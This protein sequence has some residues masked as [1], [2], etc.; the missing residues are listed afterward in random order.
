MRK[1]GA[2]FRSTTRLAGS[3]PLLLLAPGLALAQAASPHTGSPEALTRLVDDYCVSCH[4]AE[5]WAGSLAIDTLDLKQVDQEPK[6]WETTINKLR[7]RLM[8]PAGQKQPSQADVD[9]VVGFLETSLDTSAKNKV[10][11]VPIQRLNRNEFAAT[12]KELIGV[13][14]DARQA[15]PTE[16]EVEGFSNIAENLGVSPAFMEQYLSATRRAVRLAIGEPVPKMAKVFI[17]ANV[18][19]PTAYPLGTRANANAGGR[20]AGMTFTHVFPADG[21]YRVNVTEEDN[22][23]I[24]LYPRGAENPATMVI[25]VDGVE[26]GRKEI[27]GGEWLDIADRDG[28]DG[29]DVI[30]KMIS[31]PIQVKAGRREV[32]VTFIDRARALSNDSAGGGGFGGGGRINNMPIIQTGIEIEGPFQPKGLSMNESRA[33]IFVCQPKKP[34]DERPC[35]EQIARNMATKAFRRPVND[36]DVQYLMKFYEDGRQEE[37]GFDAGVTE[38]VTAILS[39]PD[40]LYRAIPA[41]ATPGE[42]R[43]LTDLE[44][45]SRLSFFLWNTVPDAQLLDL[46]TKGRLSDEA[47]MNAQVD[48]MLKD[49]RARALIENFALAWLNLDELDQVDPIDRSFTPA[50]RENFETEIRLFLASVL[51][52]NR[53]VVDLLDADWTFLNQDLAQFYGINN[54]RG[55]AFRRVKL[56]NPNR[57]GLLGKGAVLLRTSYADRTSPVVRGAWVL[58]RIMGTPPT[59]PPPG[60]ETD[61]SI[62]DGDAPTTIRQRLEVHRQNP[63]CMGCHGLIDP[64][65]LA[66][67]NFD[68]T[69][70]WRDVDAAARVAIDASTELSSGLKLNGP[71][72]LR[73]FILSREDQFPTTV[74]SRLL[75]FALNREIEYFDM[76]VVRQIVRDAKADKYRFNT[77]V[78]G[79]VN[80]MPFRH[81]GPDEHGNHSLAQTR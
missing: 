77:L 31:T 21:E 8:P 63:T 26:V 59:P 36:A 39:S 62:H 40:F 25:L 65:G 73:N 72:E 70:R 66:L 27:G 18:G 55:P 32:V 14:I 81:Q 71:V 3:V 57:H 64:P 74:T 7:G 76:P 1:S 42:P 69:G 50:V 49:D 78:K 52:E 4:N 58:E 48:R 61:L 34:A 51:L 79:V 13:D 41:P 60:V 16:V 17:P 2:F 6:V 11:H 23:D 24:G 67:E 29:K 56:D 80:S 5:D 19:R 45:A 54:V 37:G 28:A 47:V 22:V 53:S 12:V 75:M 35:A 43:K 10:G 44:L 30:L 20:G 38:L 9:A 46:A 33:K 68:N 15:L